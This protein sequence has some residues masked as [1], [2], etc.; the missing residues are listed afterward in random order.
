MLCPLLLA[1]TP[2]ET[3]LECLEPDETEAQVE[4]VPWALIK[5]ECLE[6]KKT[7]VLN[8]TLR[9]KGRHNLESVTVPTLV[10]TGVSHQS[11]NRGLVDAGA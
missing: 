11:Y 5:A 10:W 1:L 3:G 9:R 6:T 7:A 4:E 2:L 8:R